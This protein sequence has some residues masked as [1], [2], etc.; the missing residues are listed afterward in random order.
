[1][2]Q[3][4]KLALTTTAVALAAGAFAAPASAQGVEGVSATGTFQGVLTGSGLSVTYECAANAIGAA[5]SVNISKCGIFRNSAL[6]LPGPA[7]VIAGVESVPLAPFSLCWTATATFVSG[8]TKTT[9]GCT[10]RLPGAGSS[11][12]QLTGAGNSTT[13]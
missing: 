9:N 1:M 7:S 12:P 5:A 10:A 11:V 4:R 13:L 3:L 2:R 6:A 8:N